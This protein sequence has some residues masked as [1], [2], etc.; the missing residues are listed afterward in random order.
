MHAAVEANVNKE[1]TCY[2]ANLKDVTFSTLFAINTVIIFALCMTYGVGALSDPQPDKKTIE[3]SGETAADSSH[4]QDALVWL[5]GICLITVIASILSIAFVYAISTLSAHSI[6]CTMYTVLSFTGACA[7]F[8][9]LVG[10]VVGG[11]LALALLIASFVFYF[12]VKD[13]ISFAAVNMKTAG[14]AITAMPSTIFYAYGIMVVA[15]RLYDPVSYA[16][17]ILVLT[18]LCLFYLLDIVDL[19]VDH[20]SVRSGHERGIHAHLAQRSGVQHRGVH[21]IHLLG[22]R[23]SC[24]NTITYINKII[25]DLCIFHDFI[26][27]HPG[28]YISDVRL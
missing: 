4:R 15:V 23:G 1:Q 22:G 17:Q 26:D 6:S 9:L 18:I 24:N 13:R 21:D 12:Y 16:L 28:G 2:L 8:L 7:V 5:G 19:H 25:I 10:N 11:I 14:S 27:R 20:C 3:E